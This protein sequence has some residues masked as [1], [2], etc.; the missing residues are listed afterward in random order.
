MRILLVKKYLSPSSKIV[1]F[2]TGE[3]FSVEISVQ[4][5]HVLLQLKQQHFD[6]LVLIA[7]KQSVFALKKI[8]KVSQLPVMVL[9]EKIDT[10]Q[11]MDLYKYQIDDYISQH[12]DIT[13]LRFRVYALLRRIPWALS[14]SLQSSHAQQYFKRL[15]KHFQHKVDV[16]CEEN[17]A[18]IQF[19]EGLCRLQVD[20]QQLALCCEA[21]KPNDLKAITDTMDRHIAALC[22]HESVTPHWQN[23]ASQRV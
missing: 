16:H 13:E 22:R 3:G 17:K 2:L 23:N 18:L 11:R 1:D 19:E 6:L 8:R 7:D 5:N 20:H 15:C 14:T 12:I 21:D 9:T 10:Q 4:L